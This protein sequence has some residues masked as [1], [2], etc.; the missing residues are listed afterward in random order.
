MDEVLKILVKALATI[1]FA[2][3]VIFV[4]WYRY[5]KAKG[6][7]IPGQLPPKP[8]L[9]PI[10]KLGIV[11]GV[12]IVGLFLIL[13]TGVIENDP[14]PVGSTSGYSPPAPAAIPYKILERKD[15]SYASVHRF[16]YMVQVAPSASI[17]QK[18]TVIRE[19]GGEEYKK[20][21]AKAIVVYLHAEGVKYETA[22]WIYRGTYAPGGKWE[23]ADKN[24]PMQWTFEKGIE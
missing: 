19:I 24:L 9:S 21:G 11:V 22:K 15:L 12:A 5:D 1:V 16:S 8:G 18:E 2:G 17:A 3:G 10:M 13:A 7:A 6:P 20:T 4:M 14:A 23:Q